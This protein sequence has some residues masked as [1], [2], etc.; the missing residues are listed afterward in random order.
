[1]SAHRLAGPPSRR[2]NP[3]PSPGHSHRLPSWLFAGLAVMVLGLVGSLV[4]VAQQAIDTNQRITALE[5]Y[6]AGKGAQRDAENTAQNQRIDK[7]V[8]SV[9][10]QL[11]AGGRLDVVRAQYKCGPGV[12]PTTPATSKPPAA[13]TGAHPATSTPVASSST[14]A[15]SAT[16][17]AATATRIP[18]GGQA[19]RATATPAAPRLSSAPTTTAPP[20]PVGPVTSLLCNLQVLHCTAP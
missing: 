11:P 6:V 1:M 14:G 8:C 3:P 17:A 20:P 18:T 9:M 16:P 2:P 12:A 7:A 19:T 15:R 5:Q 13:S 10:D 4:L